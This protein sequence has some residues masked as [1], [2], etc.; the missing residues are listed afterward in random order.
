VRPAHLFVGTYRD[1]AD[2]MKRKGRS[3][4]LR[5]S[6]NRAARLNEAQVTEIR[7][8]FTGGMTQAALCRRFRVA[9]ATMSQII[10]RRSWTHIA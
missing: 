4:Q 3:R 1:N 2:D 6:A 10:R 9:P 7:H 8:L 5:G